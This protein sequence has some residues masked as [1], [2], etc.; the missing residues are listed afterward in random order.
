MEKLE[1]L[2]LGGPTNF[3]PA[4]LAAQTRENWAPPAKIDAATNTIMCYQQGTK[5]LAQ[6]NDHLARRQTINQN[7]AQV[8]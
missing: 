2:S 5:E 4:Y 8:P 6:T 7:K 1:L 3:A